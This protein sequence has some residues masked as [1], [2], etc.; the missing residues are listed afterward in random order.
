[1]PATYL[2]TIEKLQNQGLETLKQAQ[3]IQLATFTSLR[4][5]VA[6]VPVVTELP[7]LDKLPT[8]SELADLSTAFTAKFIE[9]QNAYVAALAGA[10]ATAQKEA[11]AA[12]DRIAKDLPK[13]K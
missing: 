5:I 6:N 7:A 2:E 13:A 1:V 12:V 4:D 3:A 11:A 8:M 9:Q 10:F